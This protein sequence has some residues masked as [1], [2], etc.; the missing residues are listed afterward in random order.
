L[1]DELFDQTRAQ[2][3]HALLRDGEARSANVEKLQSIVRGLERE[4]TSPFAVVEEL[5]RQ[6]RARSG[7]KD[8]DR[9]DDDSDAVRI[10][11]LFKAKGLEAPVVVLMHAHRSQDSVT[12]I[13]D[14]AKREIVVRFGKLMPADWE[15]RLLVEKGEL[16]MERRR[17][18]YVAATRARDQLVLCHVFTKTPGLLAPDIGARGLPDF[19]GSDTQWQPTD[20]DTATVRVVPMATQVPS[21]ASRA[22]FMS[23]DGGAALD[24]VADAAL[25]AAFAAVEQGKPLG[26]DPEGDAWARAD[27]DRTRMAARGCVR[28]R[29]P[30]RAAP[31]VEPSP[32]TTPVVAVAEAGVSVGARVGQ[33]VHEVMERI[34]LRASIEVQKTQVAQVTPLLARR[35]GLSEDESSVV[36]LISTRIVD[37]PAMTLA[38]SAPEH[39]REVPFAHPAG[40]HGVVS[41]IIDLCFPID[42]SRRRWVVFDW[43]SRLPPEGSLLRKRYEEQLA[44]Y[45][46]ALL[47]SFGDVTI[48]QT[49]LVGPHKEAGEVRSIDDVIAHTNEALR[50][51]LDVLLQGHV[52]RGGA[53]PDCEIELEDDIPSFAALCFAEERVAVLVDAEEPVVFGVGGGGA[54][55]NLEKLA[56][57]GWRICETTTEAAALLGVPLVDEASDEAE[58]GVVS[59]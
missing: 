10:T 44:T 35:S 59:G 57:R 4:L 14:H 31:V 38:R 8:I 9:L 15:T 34:D 13:V 36:A 47:K 12:T 50:A 11:T 41:G 56:A 32:S 33:V 51:G 26:G 48:E 42:E 43:K 28:W 1:L 6:A 5:V 2:A 49:I 29:S 37:H 19:V 20:D 39:W 24:V 3:A 55:Q 25:A 21:E 22:T 30:S 16:N 52:A 45:A 40:K 17:W 58:A 18:M 7:D 53:L 27:R 46:R 54:V 23:A